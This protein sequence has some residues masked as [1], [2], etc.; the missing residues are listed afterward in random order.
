[1]PEAVPFTL[2]KKTYA[3]LL[4]G[5]LLGLVA[6]FLQMIEKLTLLSSHTPLPCDLSSVFSCSV[7][8]TA[9]QSSLF[10]FPNA[11]ICIV[12]FSMFTMFSITGLMATNTSKKLHKIMLGVAT[13]FLLFALWFLYTSIFDIGAVC[14]FCLVCFAGL[15]LIVG[16]LIRLN[17]YKSDI[18]SRMVR[19][20]YDILL[21]M[22]L[23]V[24]VLGVIIIRFY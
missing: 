7:V 12:L 19:Y 16:S 17:R 18:L 15:L 24:V 13:F 21:L 3:V 8:L 4:V 20:H 10:G 22:L 9:H 5:S 2:S 6:S 1:M 11:L 23:F 14:I